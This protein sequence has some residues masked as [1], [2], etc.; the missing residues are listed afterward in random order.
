MCDTLPLNIFS[1]FHLNIRS[2]TS[3]YDKFIHYLSLFNHKFSVLALS[4][5]W[6]TEITREMFK[7]P[8]YNAVHHVRGNR[9]GGGVS[10]FIHDDYEFK[11]R[12][13]LTIKSMVEV[14]SVFVELIGVLGH[15]KIIVGVIY[16]PRLPFKRFY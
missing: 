4:E 9:P 5:T 8:K 16:R 14:E 6:L 11:L 10:L 3:N 12:H 1:A 7:V 2:L 15:K 13:D